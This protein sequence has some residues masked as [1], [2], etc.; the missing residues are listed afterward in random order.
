MSD[1]RTMNWRYVVPA[2]AGSLLVLP[3]HDEE[4]P[5][6]LSPVR[7]LSGLRAALA[8]GPYD[9]VVASDVSR[10]TSDLG[11]STSRLL[12]ALAGAVA[13][14]GHLYTGFP[15]RLYPLQ[16][17]SRGAVLPFRV[18]AAL[19]RRGL[20]V[21]STFITLPTASCPAVIVPVDSSAELD[22]VLRNLSFPYTPSSRPIVGRA[23]QTLVRAMQAAAVRAPHALRVAG[24]PGHG[25][26]A[27]RPEEV[28]S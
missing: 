8:E 16:A 28:G 3:V 6:A 26:L 15:G 9:A 24:A 4:V 22:Y 21:V 5:G 23:R 14:G 2:T 20:E 1:A 7:N 10:W 19:R 11:L 25:V 18:H 27:V 12:A 13:P 17:A